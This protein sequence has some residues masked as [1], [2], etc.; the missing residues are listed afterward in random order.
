MVIMFETAVGGMMLS[1]AIVKSPLQMLHGDTG[2]P[3]GSRTPQDSRLLIAGFFPRLFCVYNS[4][5]SPMVMATMA[6]STEQKDLKSMGFL[7]WLGMKVYDCFSARLLNSSLFLATRSAR[8]SF[9]RCRFLILSVA[10]SFS[11][12][13]P[14]FKHAMKCLQFRSITSPGSIARDSCVTSTPTSLPSIT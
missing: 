7:L 6:A 8:S 2:K 9:R 4:G 11:Y 3:L 1:S 14:D 12:G 10:A 5:P 13:T